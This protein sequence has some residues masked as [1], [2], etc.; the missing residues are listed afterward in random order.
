M[1]LSW[2]VNRLR[3]M[4]P[5]E[6]AHRLGEKARKLVSRRSHQGWSRYPSAPLHPVFPG[7]AERVLAA[8]P[9]QREAIAAAL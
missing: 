3:N 5:A 7:L 6:I 2:Y 8:S 9:E 4:E 1:K